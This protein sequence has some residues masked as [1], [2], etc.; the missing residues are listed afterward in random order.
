MKIEEI[1]DGELHYDNPM[2]KGVVIYPETVEELNII[3][4]ILLDIDSFR[5]VLKKI[6]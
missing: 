6:E 5:E 2:N 3:N 4:K 1:E